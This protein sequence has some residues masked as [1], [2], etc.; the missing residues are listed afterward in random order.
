MFLSHTVVPQLGRLKV[1]GSNNWKYFGKKAWYTGQVSI[2]KKITEKKFS[3]LNTDLKT[4]CKP[5]ISSQTLNKLRTALAYRPEPAL[6]LFEG[7]LCVY[8]VCLAED[9]K[10]L[11]H[12]TKS[13]M[14]KRLE[15]C[16]APTIIN[17]CC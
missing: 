14:K 12:G 15:T 13:E 8:L 7:E 11:Y 4:K 17:C 3:L 6:K 16:S 1:L 10:S 2:N 5:A 9:E